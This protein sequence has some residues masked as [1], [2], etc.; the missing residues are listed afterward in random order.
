MAGTQNRGDLKVFELNVEHRYLTLNADDVSAMINYANGRKQKQEIGYGSSFLSQSGR[1]LT[2]DN[3]VSSVEIT[4]SR[5]VSRKVM[6][7]NP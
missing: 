2:L 5:G 3:S 4:N 7:N 1:F 6:I